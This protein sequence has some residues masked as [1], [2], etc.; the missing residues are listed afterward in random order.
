MFKL[1]LTIYDI[2]IS[3]N[4][5]YI[6]DWIYDWISYIVIYISAFKASESVFK[7]VSETLLCYS[8]RKT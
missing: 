7:K 6:Y 5:R 4:V 1:I 3:R 8:K 2:Q